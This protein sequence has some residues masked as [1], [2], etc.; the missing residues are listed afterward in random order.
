MN[1][2]VSVSDALQVKRADEQR[3]LILDKK[4]TSVGSHGNGDY[5]RKTSITAKK[6][7]GDRPLGVY[8]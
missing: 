3:V 7:E 6:E 5:P 2:L 8:C 1:N 4:R